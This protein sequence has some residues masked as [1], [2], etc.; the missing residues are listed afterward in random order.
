MT[1]LCIPPPRLGKLWNNSTSQSKIFP[2]IFH[3]RRGEWLAYTIEPPNNGRE[4]GLP[5]FF[6]IF[7]VFEIWPK[8]GRNQVPRFPLFFHLWV[9]QWN[10]GW[11]TPLSCLTM[12]ENMVFFSLHQSCHRLTLTK[13][14]YLSS[15]IFFYFALTESIPR[16]PLTHGLPW[17]KVSCFAKN[18]SENLDSLN[19]TLLTKKQAGKINTEIAG[20]LVFKLSP[21][22]H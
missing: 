18:H 4:Y 14:L 17:G 9:F 3:N 15:K 22:C 11:L 16:L 7:L 6:G 2:W 5:Y 13:N 12:A 19:S 21:E 1:T 20:Q 8:K 10:P